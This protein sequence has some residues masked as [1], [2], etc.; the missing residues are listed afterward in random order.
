MFGLM[1]KKRF[2]STRGLT[3]S[4]AHAVK[5]C[6]ELRKMG[7]DAP[8]MQIMFIAMDNVWENEPVKWFA[9]YEER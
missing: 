9:I 8:G 1:R 3:I 2:R 5:I 7:V 6:A 4:G